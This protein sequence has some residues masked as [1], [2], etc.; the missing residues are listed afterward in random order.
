MW[1]WCR[2]VLLIINERLGMSNKEIIKDLRTRMNRVYSAIEDIG[3]SRES[4]SDASA[5][6]EI[7]DLLVIAAEKAENEVDSIESQIELVEEKICEED[8]RQEV[9]DTKKQLHELKK[10]SIDRGFDF[11]A[12]SESDEVIEAAYAE[13][14]S[15]Q[16]METPSKTRTIKISW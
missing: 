4:L 3:F 8:Y 10:Q 6:Q 15:I 13:G 9:E 1:V 16:K 5:P 2:V 12:L 11:F 14:F 7:I